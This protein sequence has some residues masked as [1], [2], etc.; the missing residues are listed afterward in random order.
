MA[1][2]I[3]PEQEAALL[4]AEAEASPAPWEYTPRDEGTPYWATVV[5]T[6]AKVAETSRF[7]NVRLIVLA[8]NL[9]PSL[10]DELAALRGE[11]QTAERALQALMLK[12]YGALR[13]SDDG[14]FLRNAIRIALAAVPGGYAPKGERQ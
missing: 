10:L 13:T 12:L 8:R 14:E 9:M 6:G 3:P 4:A 5:D 2:R 1:D 11:K 7:V